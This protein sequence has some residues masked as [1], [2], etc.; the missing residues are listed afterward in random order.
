MLS[1][2][3]RQG[4]LTTKKRFGVFEFDL[5]ARELTK[6]GVRVKVQEQPVRMLAA[7]L[8]QAGQIVSREDLQR[9]LW[10]DGTSVD[11]EQSLNK[12]VNK[13]RE[14]LG[15]SSD[16][17]I[18]IE[19]LAR[20]G[21]RFVAPVEGDRMRDPAAKTA[22]PRRRA[23]SWL[24]AGGVVAAMIL[25][26]G[27]WP[28]DLPQVERVVQ[29]TNDTTLKRSP[30]LSDGNKVLYG[31]GNDIWSVPTSGGRPKKIQLQFLPRDWFR[32]LAGYSP[33]RQ[34]ILLRSFSTGKSAA[35]ELWLT[36][37]EGEA[38]QKIGELKRPYEVAL[39]PDA[40][41]IALS[42][43]DG[44]YIQSVT[45]GA[46]EKIHPTTGMTPTLLWW[47]P[48]GHTVGFLDPSDDSRKARA[49]QINDDGTHLRRIAAEG[50][51]GGAGGWSQDGKRFS[52]LGVEGEIFLRVEAGMLGWLRKPAVTR[53]TASGQFRTPPTVDAVNPR[54]LYA[55]G[56]ILRGETVRYDRKSGRW[57]SFLNGFSGEKIDRSPD[58]QWLAYVTFP[59]FELHR[60]RIDGSSD[61]LLTPGVDAMNPSWSPDGRQIAFSGRPAGTSFNY[62]LWLVS[63][64]G[65]D[66]APYSPGTESGFDTIWSGDG[67]RILLG[68]SGLKILHLKTGKLDTIPGSDDLYSARWSP[69]EKQI[70]A[71]QLGTLKP[72]LFDPA[73]RE[74]RPL[75][76][77]Y[78]GYPKWSRDGKY[79][80]A[81]ASTLSVTEAIRIEVATG[82]RKEIARTDFRLNSSGWLGWTEDWEPVTV[83]DLSSTQVYRIDLD[84]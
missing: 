81:E 38:P 62:K 61:V 15:D 57:V 2:R 72:R 37:T 25:G 4:G 78:I 14:A 28:I 26:T 69:D 20:R 7:L 59:G 12:A 82:K 9:R 10:P 8:E 48:S 19:T 41:R 51:Y 13:L 21:Y 23:T 17:P 43:L 66:A 40:E 24:A 76:D 30:L 60:C 46:R 16:H 56:S 45:S 52:F 34:R 79:I 75:I 50:E 65:A 36:G 67:E 39:A 22:A 64:G 3:R 74:W 77:Q 47:R 83:R 58:G 55:M 18:Y 33:I 53:L 6:H 73:K 32:Y 68:A 70:L 1:N 80:Y 44:I 27:L 31:D 5:Q 71:L 49:W 29:L 42:T 84:R 11:Y 63:A 35:D 54:R